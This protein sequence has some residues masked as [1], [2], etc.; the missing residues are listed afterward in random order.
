M[1]SRN[2]PALALPA[3]VSREFESVC[4]A[5]KVDSFYGGVSISAQMRSLER[6]VDVVVGTPGRVIDL[7]QRG[8]LKLDAVSARSWGHGDRGRGYRGLGSGH[9]A[10][11]LREW[12]EACVVG[13]CCM[14]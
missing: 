7:M 6:G 10:G 4:P 14:R 5:L 8:S 13:Y 9:R 3:Q 11:P 12:T 2:A 1:R